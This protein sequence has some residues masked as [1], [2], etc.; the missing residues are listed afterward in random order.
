MGGLPAIMGGIRMVRRNLFARLDR[1]WGVLCIWITR[2]SPLPIDRTIRLLKL[3]S[4]I[5]G[6]PRPCPVGAH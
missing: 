2:R 1:I 6:L 4:D 5:T 3:I